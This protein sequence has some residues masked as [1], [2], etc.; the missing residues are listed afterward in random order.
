MGVRITEM[1]SA[2]SIAP[3]SDA[4][5]VAA[6]DRARGSAFYSE[7]LAGRSFR[8]RADLHDLPLTTKDHLRDA[9]PDGMLIVPRDRA[10]HYHESTGT[11]G[12]PISTWAGLPE[13]KRMAEL[14]R[15]SV[16]ELAGDTMLLNRFPLFS[17]VAF[18]FEEL[19]RLTGGCH[20]AADNT[21]W[22]VP[23][24]RA[25]DFLHRLQPSA[26]SCL[27]L[28]PLLLAEVA[29]DEGLD[30]HKDL[31][32][33]KVIF[34]GGAPLPPSLRRLIENDWGARVVEIYESNETMLMGVGCTEGRMHLASELLEFEIL[35]PETWEPVP[36]GGRGIVTVTSLVHTVMPLVRYV[37][38]DFVEIENDPCTCGRS[39]F[40]IRMLGRLEEK[41]EIGGRSAMHYDVLDAVHEF[42]DELGTRIF[43]VV[44]RPKDV[45]IMV[46]VEDPARQLPTKA[47]LD[48]R[49]RI[50]LPI[51]VELV[52]H[53]ELLD[54]SAF[55]RTPK[56]YKPS[57]ISDWRGEGRRTTTVME[58]LPGWPSW[59]AKTLLHLAKR[60]MRTA[61]R[62]RRLSR[63]MND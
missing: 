10:L 48:L 54:R 59:D 1:V 24:T 30:L 34:C 49:R 45:Q 18:V 17:P 29:K 36:P 57:L 58:A 23:F 43:F 8:G 12:E 22:D 11:T 2:S 35:D 13:V 56:I 44:V 61:W 5:L 21:S 27:P 47:Y 33:L 7:H 52:G 38:G 53:N 26:L 20:I 50:G 46:E 42:A 6:V 31:G 51:D 55:F 41:I 28:E 62:R 40:P 37:T 32:S 60:Q 4:E 3:V 19:S 14:I 9:S 63:G 39:G 15:A 25:V 16:P